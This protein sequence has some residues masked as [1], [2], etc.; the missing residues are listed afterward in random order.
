VTALF[1]ERIVYA[2]LTTWWVTV[3]C[4]VVVHLVVLGLLPGLAEITPQPPP[5]AAPTSPPAYEVELRRPEP[6]TPEAL[7]SSQS[8]SPA[9]R[10]PGRV[11]WSVPH[12]FNLA[13]PP[14]PLELPE[15][16]TDLS[17]EPEIALE[18]PVLPLEPETPTIAFGNHPL[19]RG[20]LSSFDPPDL[21]EGPDR[22]KTLP[23]SLDT[24]DRLLPEET[25]D[26]PAEH[27]ELPAALQL[28]GPIRRRATYP[29]P[30]PQPETAVSVTLQ[31]RFWV[32]PDGYV[33]QVTVERKG[34]P[35]LERMAIDFI[36]KWRFS[37]LPREA[38]QKNEW[39]EVTIR[40]V[41]VP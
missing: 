25:A 19:P 5:E 27:I 12:S 28:T 36:R 21:F 24:S 35:D 41:T 3:P 4:A 2:P 17:R 10:E 15:I 20:D 14:P 16:D 37:P 1:R 8:V 11:D 9:L 33:G 26:L 7:G 31:L 40:F 30:L 29:P 39:G 32:R 22:E 6:L 18:R 23:G 13:A 38:E 34:D